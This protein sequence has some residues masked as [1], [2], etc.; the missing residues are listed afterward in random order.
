M[1]RLAYILDSL[2][3]RQMRMPSGTALLDAGSAL[4]MI[5]ETPRPERRGVE[6]ER[7]LPMSG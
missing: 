4:A 3:Q 2:A 1:A 5:V 7:P 6:I